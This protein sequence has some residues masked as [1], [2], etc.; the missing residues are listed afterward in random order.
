M[1]STH[2]A[3]AR[4]DAPR[5]APRKPA[6]A[7][8]GPLIWGSA[9]LL[10]GAVF[11]SASG[12]FSGVSSSDMTAADGAPS[13]QE[14]YAGIETGSLPTIY[15]VSPQ[16]C[17]ALELDRGTNRTTA[18]SCPSDGLSLRMDPLQQPADLAALE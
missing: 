5:Q 9:G 8:R 12:V 11:C 3:A 6:V 18:R 4:R 1:P 15:V 7:G 16:N 13:H 14:D 2:D 10:A 17:T